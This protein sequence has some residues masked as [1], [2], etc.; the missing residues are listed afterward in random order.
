MNIW[1]SR[2]RIDTPWYKITGL[3]VK[4]KQEALNHGVAQGKALDDVKSARG[5][6][7]SSLKRILSLT[8]CGN[9]ADA[10]LRDTMAPLITPDTS[11]YRK[12]EDDIFGEP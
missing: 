8:R 5:E 2:S 6:I 12:L 9:T 4:S 10:F 11:I 7:Y 1:V 3:Q